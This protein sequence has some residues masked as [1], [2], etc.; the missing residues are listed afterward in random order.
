MC[1]KRI[2]QIEEQILKIKQELTEIG[3]MRPGSLT[4]QYRDPKVP[5]PET[6]AAH[7]VF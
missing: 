2:K 4:R 5:I 7:S 3:E 1:D 6:S